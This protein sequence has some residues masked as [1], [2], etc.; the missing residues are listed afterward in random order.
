MGKYATIFLNESGKIYSDE[1][2]LQV[3]CGKS[4]FYNECTFPPSFNERIIKVRCGNGYIV[5]P[6][7]ANYIIV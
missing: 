7:K 2:L 5:L 1:K 4:Y 6:I 3:S